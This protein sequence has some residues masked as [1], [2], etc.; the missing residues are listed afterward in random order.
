MVRGVVDLMSCPILREILLYI[1]IL[2]TICPASRSEGRIRIL[3]WSSLVISF[4]HPRVVLTRRMIQTSSSE[5]MAAVILKVSSSRKRGSKSW[6][7]EQS[8]HCGQ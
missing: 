2:S 8:E 6:E 5:A 3:F 7:A 1:H 4:G